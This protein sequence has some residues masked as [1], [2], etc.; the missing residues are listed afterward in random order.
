MRA[1]TTVSSRESANHRIPASTIREEIDRIVVVAEFAHSTRMQRFLIYIVEEELSGRGLLLKEYAIALNVYD[2]TADFD[3][4]LDAIV[5]VEASR[6]RAKLK[7][8]YDSAGRNDPV[9]IV[10]PR[11]SS[12]D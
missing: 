7:K 5:R 8:Y 12:I 6:L 1:D 3:P 10:V 2:K 4:R 9:N 11:N